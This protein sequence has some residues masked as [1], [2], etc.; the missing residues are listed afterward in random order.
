MLRDRLSQDAEEGTVGLGDGGRGHGRCAH[1]QQLG[2]VGFAQDGAANVEAVDQ[3]RPRR[4]AAVLLDERGQGA[5]RL[6]AHDRRDVGRHDV[7]HVDLRLEMTGERSRVGE[8]QLRMRP[9]ADRRQDALDR[10]DAA[11]LD[12]R[13][14]ARR[15]A[16][17]L[18]DGRAEH[19][20]A[21]ALLAAR[22]AAPA[23]DDQVR[24]FFGGQL[25]DSL[26]GAPADAH[27]CAQRDTG[28]RELEHPLQQAA[29]LAGTCRALG[30]C[31][32]LGHLDDAQRGKRSTGLQKR[33]ADAHEVRCRA[34]I[35]KR[36][37]DALRQLRACLARL[38]PDRRGHLRFLVG[39]LAAGSGIAD[40]RSTRY[41]LASSNARAWRS[42]NASACSVVS[43]RVSKMRLATRP[44]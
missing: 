35:G 15:V 21:A 17:D 34:R 38:L 39:G 27:D 13:D 40:H 14:V 30:Q 11:L 24:L 33:G 43:A 7:H 32:A 12:H 18:V 23:K 10:L 25:D 31:H 26:R 9:A 8:R 28:R 42:T 16:H 2:A 4:I 44:K 6:R 36:Q 5:L 37:Q 1:D 29:R 19:G 3:Q 41:G 20:L 22:P